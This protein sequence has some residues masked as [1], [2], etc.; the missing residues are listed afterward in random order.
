MS[1][2]KEINHTTHYNCSILIYQYV[3]AVLTVT[4][5]SVQMEHQMVFSI[6][7][8]LLSTQDRVFSSISLANTEKDHD[9]RSMILIT[10]SNIIL[11]HSL[12]ETGSHIQ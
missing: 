4:L 3:L 5:L 1:L 10:Y 8:V 7:S 12:L 2:Q 6:S 11:L 9:F